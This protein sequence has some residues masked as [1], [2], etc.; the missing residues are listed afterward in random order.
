MY[1][2]WGDIII[3]DFDGIFEF[4]GIISTLQGLQCSEETQEVQSNK[5]TLMLILRKE[6]AI[7]IIKDWGYSFA[8][9]TYFDN[10]H[11]L[12]I[13]EYRLDYTKDDKSY[14]RFVSNKDKLTPEEVIKASELEGKSLLQKLFGK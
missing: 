10:S 6:N 4:E 2:W 9:T 13:D 3:F 14:Y 1:I 12:T 5:M 7:K 8:P 11:R